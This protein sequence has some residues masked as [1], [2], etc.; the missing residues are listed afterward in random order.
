M[1]EPTT[2]IAI[3]T[4]ASAASLLPFLNGDSLFG[5]VIGAAFIAYYTKQAGYTSR[6]AS[7]LISTGVGYLLAQEIVDRTII[8]NFS[9]AAFIVS[10]AAIPVLL[11]VSAWLEKAT[12]SDLFSIFSK[13]GKD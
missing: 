8:K 10:I 13:K 5:A 2:P 9:T 11:K 6:I 12:L 1:A 4:T 7:F 3:T